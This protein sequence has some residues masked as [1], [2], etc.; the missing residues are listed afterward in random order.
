MRRL[1]VAI[2]AFGVFI[3]P[4]TAMAGQ[5][6]DLVAKGEKVYAANKCVTCHSI[7]AKGNKKGPLDEVGSKY[8][9]EELRKWMTHP[10]EMTAKVKSTRKP[11]MKPYDKLSAPELDAL[12]AYMQTLKKK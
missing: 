8:T 11:L 2:I 7:G 4:A 5:D 3:I 1:F 10:A 6:K 12:V 9:A